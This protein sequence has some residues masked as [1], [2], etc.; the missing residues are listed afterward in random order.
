MQCLLRR[1]FS[2]VG[3]L[4]PASLTVGRPFSYGAR[5]RRD[6]PRA[7]AAPIAVP[8]PRRSD[9]G[10]TLF[11]GLPVLVTFSLGVWQVR[12]LSRKQDM[13]AA[14]ARGLALAPLSSAAV[15]T[16]H[17]HAYRRIRL[18]GTLLHEREMLVGP[19]SAPEGVPPATVQRFGASGFLVLTPM[20]TDAG[21]VVLVGR[22]WVPAS[23]ADRERRAES[24]SPAVEVTG[25]VRGAE[26]RGRFVPENDAEKNEWFR[27][28]VAEMLGAQGM[29]DAGG[30]TQAFVE[31]VEPKP[32][33]EWP[34][35]RELEGFLQFP[36]PPS[37]HATYA[38][39]WFLLSG[40][41]ALLSRN[42]AR[43]AAK[44]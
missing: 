3:S 37:T 11:F 23:M 27:V 34:H 44:R 7:G 16:A 26:E 36:T 25:V 9:W 12:R 24:G 17:E 20:R 41:L 30:T 43:K 6:P 42:R 38:A 4:R 39:T 10:S 15:P 31:L 35:P 28:D 14:R 19:R 40:A 2:P 21:D 32:A 33:G 5:H 1:A 13:I 18:A 22:G 29:G 8:P